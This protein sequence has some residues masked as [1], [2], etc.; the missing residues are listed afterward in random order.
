MTNSVGVST[1]L[2][3]ILLLAMVYL[4]EHC[5]FELLPTS[6]KIILSVLYLSA[7]MSH[8]YVVYNGMLYFCSTLRNWVT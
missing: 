1:L 3:V 4:E 2:N 6:C 8:L 5:T 7:A